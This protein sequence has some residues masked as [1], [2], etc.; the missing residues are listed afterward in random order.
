MRPTA[1]GSPSSCH[2]GRNFLTAP[3]TYG[4]LYTRYAAWVFRQ[5]AHRADRLITITEFSRSEISR[6]LDVDGAHICRV[7]RSQSASTGDHSAAARW[8]IRTVRR[9]HRA[10]HEPRPAARCLGRNEPG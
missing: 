9:R 3:G 4:A 7:P 5:S 6:H 10:Q 2:D 1:A 8:T